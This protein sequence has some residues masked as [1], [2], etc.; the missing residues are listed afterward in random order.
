MTS[1][2]KLKLLLPGIV[3]FSAY[4]IANKFFPE[5]MKSFDDPLTGLRGDGRLAKIFP[6]IFKRFSRFSRDR[7]LKIGLLALFGTTAFL[8]F[9]E[10]EA[11]LIDDVFDYFCV[12][13]AEKNL[14]IGCG[15]SEEPELLLHTNNMRDIIV[16]DIL[17][18]EH[19]L[20]LL[21]LKLD[22]LINGECMERSRFVVMGIIVALL[23][24]T[25]SNVGGLVLLVE[26][27]YRLVQQGKI[28]KALYKQ[29]L[30]ALAKRWGK[31]AVPVEY[32]LD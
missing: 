32:L 28:S 12:Q 4:L 30:K 11:L 20:F 16:D 21:K 23:T 2:S 17:S 14:K 6:K 15:I 29:I 18:D 9:Q 25:I 27:L 26:A 22:I 24:F 31:N 3:G 13:E 5:E 19:K 1:I 7:A 10:L 8:Y